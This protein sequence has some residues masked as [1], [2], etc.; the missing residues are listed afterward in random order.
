[1]FCDACGQTLQA[2]QAFCG[3]C[4][5]RVINSVIAIPVRGGR[6]REHVRLLGIL[7][8]A[9]AGLNS[10][11]AVFINV[12]NALYGHHLNMP[13]L[14]HDLLSVFCYSLLGLSA[15]G[16]AAGFGLMR[17][18]VWARTLTL[19]LA[20]IALFTNVPFGTALGIY[21]MWV[22]MPQE[23]EREYETIALREAA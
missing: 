6:V 22:L 15:L 7:W 10:I 11:G 5:K 4:G 8:L 17:R 1:M 20:F 16:L 19:I 18:E 23:S 12:A 9:Y 13:P 14:M 3:R 21:T 2:G